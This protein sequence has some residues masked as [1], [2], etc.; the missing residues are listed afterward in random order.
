MDFLDNSILN[1]KFFNVFQVG[2]GVFAGK[3]IL[4]KICIFIV[5]ILLIL[6][7]AQPLS[8]VSQNFKAGAPMAL[9]ITTSFIATVMII[10]LGLSMFKPSKVISYF[11]AFF[12][13]VFYV[14]TLTMTI[15]GKPDL[16]SSGKAYL[17]IKLVFYLALFST[18][19]ISMFVKADSEKEYN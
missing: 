13:I 2:G 4:K 11:L 9:A 3:D 6:E 18:L 10:I 5:F 12:V 15:L 16:S 1:N 8:K 19:I 7:I 17:Y 14:L